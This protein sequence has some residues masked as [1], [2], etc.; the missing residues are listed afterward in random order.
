M[1]LLLLVLAVALG[2]SAL[3]REVFDSSTHHQSEKNEEFGVETID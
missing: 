3:A 2:P 1:V